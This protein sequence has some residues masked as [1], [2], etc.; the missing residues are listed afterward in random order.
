MCQEPTSTGASPELNGLASPPTIIDD[1]ALNAG[2]PT[3][4][5][6]EQVTSPFNA[7][8]HAEAGRRAEEVHAAY[9]AG[10]THWKHIALAPFAISRE[11]DWLLH[12]TTLGCPPLEQIITRPQ[13]ML[14]D[15]LRVLWFLAHDPSAWLSIAS[16]HEIDG[17]W[18]VRSA[19]DRA[20]EI[21]ASI[22]AWADEHV[23]SSEHALAVMLFYQLYNGT[24]ET[25]ATVKPSRNHDPEKAGN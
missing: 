21:E 17:R 23:E 5:H 16:M 11:G 19:H 10:T 25:R 4:G 3:P 13:A 20:M 1:P 8:D 7:A 18:H 22:R 24:R 12:R 2:A 9:S 6:S 14:S 15:A